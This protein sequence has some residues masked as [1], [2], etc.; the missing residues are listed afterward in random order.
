MRAYQALTC[1]SGFLTCAD[2]DKPGPGLAHAG[3]HSLI[4]RI[5]STALEGHLDARGIP[6]ARVE[7]QP[8][9]CAFAAAFPQSPQMRKPGR[10]FSIQMF[11]MEP[12]L[13]QSEKLKG[14][15]WRRLQRRW[16]PGMFCDSC[17]LVIPPAFR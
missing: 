6:G 10:W 11:W 9:P 15:E 12:R 3:L 16:T 13:K 7:R 8:E 17:E 5:L 14:Q 1:G 4:G 2:K